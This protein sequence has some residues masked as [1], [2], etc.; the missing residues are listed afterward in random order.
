M[1]LIKPSF[2][3]WEQE[4]GLNGVFRQIEREQVEYVINQ[5]IR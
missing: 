3:I 2:K 1:K 4:A 5:K